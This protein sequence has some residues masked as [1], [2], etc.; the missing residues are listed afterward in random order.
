LGS[1][2]ILP[3]D[4]RFISATNM[5]IYQAVNSGSFR[6]DLLYRINTLE[7]HVPPLRERGQ[8]IILL[9]NHFIE[10]F[11][12][13]YKKDINGLSPEAKAK[14]MDYAWP[15]NVRE[16]QNVMERSVIL[17]SDKTLKAGSISLQIN[18]KRKENENLNLNEIEQ[19]VIEKALK[20]SGGNLSK[21]A[22]LLGITRYTLYRKI[23]KE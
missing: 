13:K 9:A 15:G 10:K 2:R 14:I 21:A 3:I 12:H 20:R 6:Q 23:K 19:E 5:D 18:E 16:L 4:V 8:D 11:A 7:I 1:T 17:S 22:G